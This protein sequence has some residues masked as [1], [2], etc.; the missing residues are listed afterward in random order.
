MLRDATP[1]NEW[2]YNL[3]KNISDYRFVKY[4]YEALYVNE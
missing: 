4:N 3:Q 1:L 2:I